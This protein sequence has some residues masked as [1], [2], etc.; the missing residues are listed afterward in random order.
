ML[1]PVLVLLKMY[2]KFSSILYFHYWHPELH[3]PEKFHPLKKLTGTNT[4]ANTIEVAIKAPDNSCM[5]L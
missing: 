2:N 5:A 4:A 3:I 1:H